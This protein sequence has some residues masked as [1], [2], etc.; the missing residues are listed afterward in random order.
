MLYFVLS[1]ASHGGGGGADEGSVHTFGIGEREKRWEDGDKKNN[2]L[3]LN[4]YKG[5]A[6]ITKVVRAGYIQL[7]FG[8]CQFTI[9]NTPISISP[10]FA[11]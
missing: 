1:F 7:H 9:L 6:R 4:I 3:S 11:F 10:L 2:F 8:P 5:S